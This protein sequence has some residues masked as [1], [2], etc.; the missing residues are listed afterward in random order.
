M[1]H[2]VNL[3]CISESARRRIQ[4]YQTKRSSLDLHTRTYQDLGSF[5]DV[6]SG[7][8]GMKV[9]STSTEKKERKVQSH[10]ALGGAVK[11]E[12]W[13]LRADATDLQDLDGIEEFRS[14][15]AT[16]YVGQVH[17][18]PGEAGFLY[19]LSVEFL[20]TFTLQHFLTLILDG[21]IYDLVKSGSHALVLKPFIAAYRSLKAKNIER[22]RRMQIDTLLLSF[23]DSVV[24]IDNLGEDAILDNLEVVLET[25]ASNYSRLILGTSE[26]PFSIV[27]PIFEDPSSDR[28]CRFRQILDVDETIRNM[29]SEDYLNLWGVQYDYSCA[30]RVFR[31]KD[32]LL[33]EDE[34]YTRRQY[35]Q[36]MERRWKT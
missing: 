3:L 16:N 15:L 17:A 13:A 27:I 5:F 10:M 19:G 24:Q 9:S 6:N 26:K 2:K 20:T 12:Y 25:L 18:R 32:Q 29:T 21:I 1:I 4:L 31:V 28:P 11:V 35:W 34:F 23:Q 36:A 7:G 30:N 33:S 22:K 8:V 14:E